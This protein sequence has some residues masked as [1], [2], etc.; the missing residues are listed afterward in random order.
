MEDTY[1]DP[2][3][4]FAHLYQANSPESA[5]PRN[6]SQP[7]SKYGDRRRCIQTSTEEAHD[8]AAG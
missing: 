5:I 4:L 7:I 1:S 6:H 8:Q 3:R 2:H